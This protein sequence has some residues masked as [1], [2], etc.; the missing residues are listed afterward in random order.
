MRPHRTE[1]GERR[2][3]RE[4]YGRPAYERPPPSYGQSEE[5]DYR[6]PSYE[7]RDEDEGYGR[8]KYVSDSPSFAI[9]LI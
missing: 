7:K 2:E 6:K 4:E 1:Y 3:E 8:K 9:L 5:E